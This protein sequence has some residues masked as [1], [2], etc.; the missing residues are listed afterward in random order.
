MFIVYA[1]VS[2]EYKRYVGHT[3][4]LKARLLERN[5][6]MCKTT[7]PGA[8]WRVAYTEEFPTRGEAMKRELWLKTGAGRRYL[9]SVAAGWSPP[10]AE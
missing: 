10:A 5:S 4:D 7:K 9:Q 1:I 3:G 2:S 6:G 8:N